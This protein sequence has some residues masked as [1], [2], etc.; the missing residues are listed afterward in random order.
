MVWYNSTSGM[1][2]FHMVLYDCTSG[3][4]WFHKVWY[5]STSGMVWFH[6]VW[7]DSTSGMVWLHM[8]WYDSTSG[9]NPWYYSIPHGMVWFHLWYDSMVGF[10]SYGMVWCCL[11][12][13]IISPLWICKIRKILAV[14]QIGRVVE[15]TGWH[16]AHMF[17]KH[18]LTCSLIGQCQWHLFLLLSL[19]DDIEDRILIEIT[20]E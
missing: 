13:G 17:L 1:V 14:L 9:M 19:I 16:I 18:L 7:Y 10:Y 12:Y 5:N 20:V 6:M 8:V 2:W 11:W 3:M 15:R 4:V